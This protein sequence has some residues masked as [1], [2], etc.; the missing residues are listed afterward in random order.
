MAGIEG[1][2]PSGGSRER[3]G[4]GAG[5]AHVGQRENIRQ[6]KMSGPGANS[7]GV[8]KTSLLTPGSVKKRS[9][10]VRSDEDDGGCGGKGHAFDFIKIDSRAT[11]AGENA[12]S[13][14]VLADGSPQSNRNAQRGEGIGS[15]GSV[16]AEVLLDGIDPDRESVFDAL[17]GANQDILDQI[18]R[19]ENFTAN[20]QVQMIN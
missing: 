18:A 1:R 17:H 14:I 19:H 8:E 7:A 3:E 2:G 15:I 16:S 10:S 6:V 4:F 13:E 12:V 20:P 11:K 5:V 9:G